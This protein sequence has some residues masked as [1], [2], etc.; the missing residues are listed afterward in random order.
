MYFVSGLLH[1]HID[2]DLLHHIASDAIVH[3]LV[4]LGN[5]FMY[6]FRLLLIFIFILVYL[7][8]ISVKEACILLN[9]SA[10]SGMLIKEVLK[11]VLHSSSPQHPVTDPVAALHD[12]G[13]F[14]L[15]LEQAELVLSLRVDWK[16]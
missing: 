10:G 9:L 14:K 13:V 1:G 5:S 2:Y 16:L 8:V 11:Q 4:C 15:T 12:V 6:I 3:G 7:F